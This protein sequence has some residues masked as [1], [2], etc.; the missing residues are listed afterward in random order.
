M[1]KPRKRIIKALQLVVSILALFILVILLFYVKN[2]I[3]GRLNAWQVKIPRNEAEFKQVSDDIVFGVIYSATEGGI[4]KILGQ[5]E[6]F[7]EESEI[8]APARSIR[9]DTKKTVDDI[10]ARLKALPAEEFKIIKE[11]IGETW[12]KQE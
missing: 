2:R 5:S 4:K 7:F 1:G 11:K 3:E 8:T 9:D 6:V 10:L 12:F